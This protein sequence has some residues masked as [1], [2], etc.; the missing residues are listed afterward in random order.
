MGCLRGV[1]A[2]EKLRQTVTFDV[3]DFIQ[4]EP[5]SSVGRELDWVGVCNL[6]HLS[7]VILL[8]M[9]VGGGLYL[10]L[11]LLVSSRCDILGLLL[12]LVD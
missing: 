3:M 11:G 7:L 9:L 5:F 1:A 12:L 4:G 8:M 6:L 10:K 2:V